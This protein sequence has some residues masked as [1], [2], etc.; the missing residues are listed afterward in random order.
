LSAQARPP[1]RTTLRPLES[2]SAAGMGSG[3]EWACPCLRVGDLWTPC[4]RECLLAHLCRRFRALPWTS[5]EFGRSAPT[6]RPGCSLPKTPAFLSL[7]RGAE[8]TRVQM[9]ARRVSGS[10][11]METLSASID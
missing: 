7:H 8:G 9:G 11:A 3:G 6:G 2:R 10:R 5:L 1:I 4:S